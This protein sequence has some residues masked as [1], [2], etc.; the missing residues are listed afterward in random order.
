[1]FFQLPASDH[2]P[3]A[4]RRFHR[5]RFFK[6][7]MGNSAATSFLYS[8]CTGKIFPIQ[9]QLIKLTLRRLFRIW[10]FFLKLATFAR[11]LTFIKISS[12]Y[13]RKTIRV[14]ESIFRVPAARLLPKLRAD[15]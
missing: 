2:S 13:S 12:G 6:K 8:Y 15:N 1:M 14:F 9:P 3:N 10:K 5:L 4:K 11:L 7:P